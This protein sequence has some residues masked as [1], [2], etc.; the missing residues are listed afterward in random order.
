VPR[1]AHKPR[2]DAP[3][4]FARP[5]SEPV[6][7]ERGLARALTP[8]Q[9]RVLGMVEEGMGSAEIARALDVCRQNV[10]AMR[11]RIRERLGL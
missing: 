7:P 8:K 2:L 5:R 6:Y 11:Q 10:C 9:L 3:G 4:A 1:N